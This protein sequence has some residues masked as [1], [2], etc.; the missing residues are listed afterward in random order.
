[1][2]AVR[3]IDDGV[4]EED[5]VV[6]P[7][8]AFVVCVLQAEAAEFAGVIFDECGL[9]VWRMPEI[10]EP[11]AGQCRSR[12]R[13]AQPRIT[14]SDAPLR[15]ELVDALRVPAPAV[16]RLANAVIEPGLVA[17]EQLARERE[18]LDGWIAARRPFV[19]KARQAEIVVAGE[20]MAVA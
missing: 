4:L 19:D 3:P 14:Q 6:R 11:A 7:E 17:V 15:H 16:L 9:G 20:E 8:V 2:G 1:M 18:V 5:F 12:I 10:V 13:T